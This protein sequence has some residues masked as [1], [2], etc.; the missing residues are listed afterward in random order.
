MN[1]YVAFM[2]AIVLTLF[3]IGVLLPFSV[4][5]WKTMLQRIAF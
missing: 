3:A 4:M 2:L 5:L 1:R